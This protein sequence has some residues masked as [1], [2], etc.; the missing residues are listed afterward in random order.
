MA[1]SSGVAP[2]GLVTTEVDA[3]AKDG[4]AAA[5]LAFFALALGVAGAVLGVTVVWFSAAV[6]LGVA[7]VVT[8][9]V[10]LRRPHIGSHRSR[11]V[12]GIVLGLVALLLGILSAILL[13]MVLHRADDALTGAR[14][15]IVSQVDR[16]DRSLASDVD[17]LDTTISRELRQ[18]ER[19]NDR[20]LTGFERTSADDLRR[21][22][23]RMAAAEKDLP[24]QK[25]DL[26]RLNRELRAQ[27]ATLGTST[28]GA[29]VAAQRGIEAITARVV[30]LEDRL[31]L[32]PAP[33]AEP[34]APEQAVTG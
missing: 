14:D 16:V 21:L 22:E 31:G 25:S 4:V 23:H 17:Q 29:D 5:N 9:G 3:A 27:I 24:L 11:A 15:D 1:G 12:L 6:P 20:E 2:L 28:N 26:A 19:Q 8:G 30:A 10:A 13:P 7:A 18:L 32:S 34:T 33:A